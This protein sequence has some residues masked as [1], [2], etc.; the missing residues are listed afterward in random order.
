MERDPPLV[1]PDTTH[2]SQFATQSVTCVIFRE[3]LYVMPFFQMFKQEMV[4]NFDHTVMNFLL[5][6]KGT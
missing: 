2:P 3:E 5:R 1:P 4:L 6:L